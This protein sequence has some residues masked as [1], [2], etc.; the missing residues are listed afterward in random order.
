MMC[1]NIQQKQTNITQTPMA[2]YNARLRNLLPNG[3][4]SIP[5]GKE[6]AVRLESDGTLSPYLRNIQ[7]RRHIYTPTTTLQKPLVES[8][9]LGPHSE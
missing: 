8:I 1:N 3:R 6:V 9:N 2:L 4:H 5:L 7:E